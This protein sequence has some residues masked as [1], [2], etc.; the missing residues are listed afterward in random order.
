MDVDFTSVRLSSHW[1]D[2][3]RQKFKDEMGYQYVHK[4]ENMDLGV[5][6]TDD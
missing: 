4:I 5:L 1:K 3:V 6:L 2:G